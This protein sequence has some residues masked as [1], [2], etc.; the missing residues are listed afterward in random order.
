MLAAADMPCE[1]KTTRS[2]AKMFGASLYAS[3]REFAR[4]HHQACAVYV[5]EPLEW[6]E[7]RRH[8]DRS[9]RADRNDHHSAPDLPMK[10]P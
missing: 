2:L 8:D 5:L 9:K 4:T 10:A 7:G 3:A 6:V 1:L